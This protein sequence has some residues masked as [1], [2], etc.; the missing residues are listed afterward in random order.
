VKANCVPIPYRIDRSIGFAAARIPYM[1]D[2]NGFYMNVVFINQLHKQYGPEGVEFLTFQINPN[3][4]DEQILEGLKNRLR[5]NYNG[6][7]IDLQ[8]VK[9]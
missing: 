5:I 2:E 8:E 6:H 1:Q 3:Q 7:C 9:K 4:T